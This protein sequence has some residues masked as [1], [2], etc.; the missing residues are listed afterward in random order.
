VAAG[1]GEGTAAV[2]GT[3]VTGVGEGVWV[4]VCSR[5][6]VA[7]TVVALVVLPSSTLVASAF[8]AVSNNVAIRAR[9]ARFNMTMCRYPLV[10]K[11]HED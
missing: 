8:L 9:R 3:S 4:A 11:E 7:E 6:L 2:T 5:R 10:F 1:A